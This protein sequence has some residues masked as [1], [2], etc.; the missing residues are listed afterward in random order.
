[1]T[2]A[3]IY[4]R[5]PHVYHCHL[6]FRSIIVTLCLAVAYSNITNAQTNFTVDVGSRKQLNCTSTTTE[7]YPSWTLSKDGTDENTAVIAS[8]CVINSD[9]ND[10]YEVKSDGPGVCNLVIT[11][12]TLAET[13]VYTCI[14]VGLASHSS[15]VTVGK[16]H[17]MFNARYILIHVH[18]HVG[19]ILQG[20]TLQKTPNS[21]Y[22]SP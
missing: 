3:T 11:N 9:Y 2:H 16:Y 13:G 20:N 6:N 18:V 4:N 22:T 15:V 21:T 8:F 10:M 7:V 14:D 5:H 17:I 12:A 19:P 1:M